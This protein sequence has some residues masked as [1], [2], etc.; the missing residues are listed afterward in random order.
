MDLTLRAAER[1]DVPVLVRLLADDVLG[2]DRE[3]A[4]ESV[5]EGYWRAFSTIDEDERQLLI[6]AE[7]EGIVVGTM[8]LT[9]IQYLTFL[10]GERAQIEAVRVAHAYRGL[11]IGRRM[12]EWAIDLARSRGCH[13]VQLTTNRRR[14]GARDFYESMGFEATHHGMKLMLTR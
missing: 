11:G 4:S 10:G 7:T 3:K 14:E 6:V 8:Q 2:K 12:L 5:D 1:D 9:F 13:L